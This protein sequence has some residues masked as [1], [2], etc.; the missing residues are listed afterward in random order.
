M[1]KNVIYTPLFRI[2]IPIPYGALIYLLLLMINNNLLS[3]N[4]SFISAELFFCIG[5]SYLTFEANRFLLDRIFRKNEIT[6]MSNLVMISVNVAVT[7]ALIYGSLHLYFVGFLGFTS[8]AGFETEVKSFSVFFGITSILYTALSISYTLLNKRN[9]Q[10]L[11]DEETLKAQIQYE[12]DSYQAE[13]NPDLLFESLESALTLIDKDVDLAE[14]YIDQLALVYR[15]MLSNRN[16]DVIDVADELEAAKTLIGL[17]NVRYDDLIQL[18]SNHSLESLKIIPGSLPLLIE[19]II[20]SSLIYKG[21]PLQIVLDKED[22]YLTLSHK[23]NER[24]V[25]NEHEML[26]FKRLQN[27]YSYYSDQPLVK[28]QA[29]G[30]SFYKIPIISESA[31]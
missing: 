21:R 5:L 17:H 16:N 20:K 2:F 7:L 18:T 11:D 31:A 6:A 14:D 15:Y 22:N 27:A 3:L 12:L 26:T 28:V 10:L 9:E 25:K 30:D 24:L 8:V 23:M 13:V 1:K 4:E 19:E 29:Y